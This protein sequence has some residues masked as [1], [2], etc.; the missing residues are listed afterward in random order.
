[1]FKI[2]QCK[3]GVIKKSELCIFCFIVRETRYNYAIKM[4]NI[5]EIRITMYTGRNTMHRYLDLKRGAVP[6]RTK[7]M[8]R[9]TMH[10]EYSNCN[11]IKQDLFCKK[12]YI[13]THDQMT[14]GSESAN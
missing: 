3:N 8:F 7:K 12:K 10:W 9:Q 2:F 1:M 14:V 6:G 5:C 13:C 11:A 4:L